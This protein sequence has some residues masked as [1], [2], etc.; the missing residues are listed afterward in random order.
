MHTLVA[1]CAE[2][3]VVTWLHACIPAEAEVLLHYL[4]DT[5]N[6][7]LALTRAK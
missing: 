5:D 1:G 6:G 3:F 4:K 2:T 7:V